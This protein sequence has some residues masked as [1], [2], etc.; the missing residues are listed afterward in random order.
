[1]SD[2]SANRTFEPTV[3]TPPYSNGGDYYF[4]R[5]SLENEARVLR[6]AGVS[7]K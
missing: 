4:F 2:L 5:D 3:T 7:N 1:M 6:T